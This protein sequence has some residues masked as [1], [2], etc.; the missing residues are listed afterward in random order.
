MKLTPSFNVK[1]FFLP[2]AF[3]LASV[4]NAFVI[5]NDNDW[6]NFNFWHLKKPP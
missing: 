1:E 3:F 4:K 5:E 2:T 6:V